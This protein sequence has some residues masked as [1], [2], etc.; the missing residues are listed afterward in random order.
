M[1]KL[2]GISREREPDTYVP[3]IGH[4]TPNGALS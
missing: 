4:A 3:Y 1:L 2:A